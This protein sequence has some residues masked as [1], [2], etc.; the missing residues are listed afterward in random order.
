MHEIKVGDRLRD[1]GSVVRVTAVTK[2]G[3]RYEFEGDPPRHPRLGL[4]WA[5]DGHEHFGI[6]GVAL[7]HRIADR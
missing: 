2:N 5:K 6:G 3:F 7:F 1:G 4:Q